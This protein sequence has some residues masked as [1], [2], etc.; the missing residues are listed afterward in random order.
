M[1]LKVLEILQF[2]PSRTMD[3]PAALTE[4]PCR[5]S[6]KMEVNFLMKWKWKWKPY[7]L[8]NHLQ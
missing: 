7:I 8:C 1:V 5:Y 4:F 6:Y 2:S 3:I